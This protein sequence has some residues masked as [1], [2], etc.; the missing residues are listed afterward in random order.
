MTTFEHT[1]TLGDDETM[2]MKY[3]LQL[4]I[5]HCQKK[6]DEGERAPYFLYKELAEDVLKSLRESRTQTSGNNFF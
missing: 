6:L 1:L 4:M 5:G 2:M 3:A